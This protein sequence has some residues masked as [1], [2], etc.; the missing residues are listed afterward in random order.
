MIIGVLA[1]VFASLAYGVSSVLQAYGARQSHDRAVERGE[2]G[3]ATDTGGPTLR[4][5]VLAM[6]TVAFIVGT[7]LDVGGFVGSAISAR[8]VPLF[9]SQTVVSANL[10]VTAIL[11]IVV[12]GIRLHMRDWI[13]IAVVIGALCALGLAAKEDPHAGETWAFHW[14]LLAAT[15]VLFAASLGLIRWLGS[16]AAVAAGLCAGVLF[17]AVAIAVR[18]LDGFDPFDPV[19]ILTDPAMYALALSGV[20]GFYLHTV[21]LQLGS[22]NGAT[23][24]LVVGETVVPGVI[25]VVLLGDKTQPGLAWL[26]VLGFV[27]AVCGAVA[28]AWSGAAEASAPTQSDDTP[29]ASR[30]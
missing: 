7:V 2:T 17:G 9:L 8:L 27:A 24:A 12:L 29:A 19:T 23:A 6:L 20:G 26:A 21:A 5:T 1:A 14:G 25:G 10:I 13:A 16:R 28:V 4:S 15:V 3:I 18:V 30:G 11:G 22:V